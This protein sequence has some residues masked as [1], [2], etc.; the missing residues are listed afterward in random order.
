MV[1]L[2]EKFC[3]IG[4]YIFSLEYFL[5]L[6]SKH[7]RACCS[8]MWLMTDRWENTYFIGNNG[9]GICVASFS[10]N[11]CYL[12]L[13][14]TEMTWNALINFLCCHIK[15][16][17]RSPMVNITTSLVTVNGKLYCVDS[18]LFWFNP[19]C[20]CCSISTIK[21]VYHVNRLKL[22]TKQHNWQS[23]T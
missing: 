1:I 22:Q 9:L 17:D 6:F 13:H 15:K 5:I 12:I 2:D 11:S 19:W 3:K 23:K 4:M 20:V 7:E 16:R 14:Q 10:H 21:K 8:W 18:F